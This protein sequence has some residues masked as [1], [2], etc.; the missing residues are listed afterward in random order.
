MKKLSLILLATTVLLVAWTYA[1]ST[2]SYSKGY[3]QGFADEY[4]RMS[5]GHHAGW[6]CHPE[7]VR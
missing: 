2:I 3:V 1:V 6:A 4:R 7:P 5:S